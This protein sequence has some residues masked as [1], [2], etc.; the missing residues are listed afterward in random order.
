MNGEALGEKIQSEEN[1]LGQLTAKNMDNAG[2]VGQ[3]FER[4]YARPPTA[5][6]LDIVLVHVTSEL[7]AGRGRRQTLESVLWS[8][9]NS[10]EF[11]LNH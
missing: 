2:I 3:I 10:K 11:Q 5:K 6:E 1:V 9:I 7:A 4:A 8:V